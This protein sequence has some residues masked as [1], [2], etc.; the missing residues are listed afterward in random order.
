MPGERSKLSASPF[1]AASAPVSRTPF[2]QLVLQADGART[3]LVG[4][5]VHAGQRGQRV[6]PQLLT[7]DAHALRGDGQAPVRRGGDRVQHGDRD[8]ETAH[9]AREREVAAVRAGLHVPHRLGQLLGQFVV[10]HRDGGRPRVRAAVGGHAVQG[11][12]HGEGRPPSRRT[13]S[14]LMCTVPTRPVRVFNPASGSVS[15]AC[16]PLAESPS[17]ARTASVARC[18]ASCS[19]NALAPPPP[20]ATT[21]ASAETV[22]R[23][24]RRVFMGVVLPVWDAA[25]GRWRRGTARARGQGLDRCTPGGRP[26]VRVGG[27]GWGGWR[28]WPTASSVSASGPGCCGGAGGTAR[29]GAGAPGPPDRRF[30]Q[31]PASGSATGGCRSGESTFGGVCHDIPSAPCAL[32]HTARPRT[33]LCAGTRTERG[34]CVLP[35][36]AARARAAAVRCATGVSAPRSRPAAAGK[37]ERS[38]AACRRSGLG[39]CVPRCAGDAGFGTAR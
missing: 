24:V 12:V 28:R 20:A 26:A 6:D 21:A 27:G 17:S 38:P 22:T 3:E 34:T 13:S 36:G 1:S 16:T 32:W 15:S 10:T 5:P 14:A 30:R 35:A 4:E 29:P 19:T 37:V 8:P 2:G 9:G 11:R 7:H 31:V 25:P 18:C 33:P 23:T 39:R